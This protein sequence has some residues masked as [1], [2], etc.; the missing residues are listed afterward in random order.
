VWEAEST[1]PDGVV[2]ALQ[3]AGV[4][5]KGASAAVVGCG[6]A[7]KAAAYGLHL[8]GAKVV[9]VN[10]GR[11]RGQKAS[12]ALG[13]PFVPLA[14]FDPSR[15]DVV[16]QATGLGH[17]PDDDLIF[18]PE[19]L[20]SG[21][22]LLDMVYGPEPTRL[23]RRARELGR[24]AVDGREMLLYQALEQFRLMTGRELPMELAREILGLEEERQ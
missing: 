9:L 18:D 8:A 1:D 16:V 19:R 11:E 5:L 13:L 17:D 3:H 7:G 21:A 12:A 6:G 23:L 20:A 22:A 14:D 15:F 10:R 4:N 24:I 2:L